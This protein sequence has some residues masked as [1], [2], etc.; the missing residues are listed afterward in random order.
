[1]LWIMKRACWEYIQV[2]KKIAVPVHL[3][4]V[5]CAPSFPPA[6]TSTTSL[7]QY[8]CTSSLLK[9]LVLTPSPFPHTPG[10]NLPLAVHVAGPS[11]TPPGPNEHS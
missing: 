5:A 4:V 7:P 2:E 1:M 9:V 8:L 11:T 10:S 3:V 6:V